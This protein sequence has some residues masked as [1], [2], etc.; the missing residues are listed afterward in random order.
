MMDEIDDDTDLEDIAFNSKDETFSWL[1]AAMDKGDEGDFSKKFKRIDM[2]WVNKEEIPS[3]LVVENEVRKI[4]K[5]KSFNTGTSI[6]GKGEVMVRDNSCVCER[7]LSGEV[8]ECD[9][10][11]NGTYSCFDLVN[12]SI[13][14]NQKGKIEGTDE[15][16][17]EVSDEEEL[18]Y[19]SEIDDLS[20]SG[21]SDES[22]DEEEESNLSIDDVYDG[23]Y[24]L[25]NENYIGTVTD[26]SYGVKYEITVTNEKV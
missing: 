10:K 8:L 14:S 11:K 16:E 24:V 12:K 5:V 9:A 1:K 17:D 20:E 26:V 21:S 13:R 6:A 22:S 25:Y 7:C 4:P 2:I 15:S 23:R 19:H 3:K 18:E